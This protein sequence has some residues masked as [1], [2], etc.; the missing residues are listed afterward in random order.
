MSCYS[1]KGREEKSTLDKP[2]ETI[3]RH[4][5]V[6]PA[7]SSSNT[8]SNTS[9]SAIGNG[10]HLLGIGSYNSNN[11][12]ST[13]NN[14]GGS[15]NNNNTPTI[16]ITAD[17]MSPDKPRRPST[18]SLGPFSVSG[19]TDFLSRAGGTVSSSSG[20]G[21]GGAGAGAASSSRDSGTDRLR[22]SPHHRRPSMAGILPLSPAESR[23]PSTHSVGILPISMFGE[24]GEKPR[25]PSTHS[26][27]VFSFGCLGEDKPERPRRCSAHSLGPLVVPDFDRRGSRGSIFGTLGIGDFVGG[28]GGAGTHSHHN[29]RRPSFQAFGESVVSV[30]GDRAASNHQQVE[31]GIE[32]FQFNN[33]SRTSSKLE[34]L[35]L[36]LARIT[37]QSRYINQ[38]NFSTTSETNVLMQNRISPHYCAPTSG[39]N[40]TPEK[41]TG[42]CNCVWGVSA[43]LPRDTASLTSHARSRPPPT[44]DTSQA[45]ITTFT[46]L[47]LRL[48]TFDQLI[49]LTLT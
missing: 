6:P 43:Y 30:S 23:R 12:S 24:G 18:H 36:S 42:P 37:K 3:R 48:R 47:L 25:R 15:S 29:Q 45:A 20:S 35:N 21:G 28:G 13:A 34:S 7:S 19:L 40:G 17:D 2:I 38:C 32:W 39:S 16:S 49:F 5:L 27:G 33:S 4:S 14:S 1:V 31:N 8:N 46:S 41:K 44:I 9:S 22:S 26:L 11:S 10:T